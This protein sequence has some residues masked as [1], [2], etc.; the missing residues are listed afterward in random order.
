MLYFYLNIKFYLNQEHY[1]KTLFISYMKSYYN[2]LFAHNLY[3]FL[4]K[5]KNLKPI[6]KL[7]LVLIYK[8]QHQIETQNCPISQDPK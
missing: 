5:K 6:Q 2:Y 4:R 1:P 7:V 3:K 8:P